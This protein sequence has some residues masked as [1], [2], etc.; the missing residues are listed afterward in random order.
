MFDSPLEL[1]NRICH[2]GHAAS[3]D[4]FLRQLAVNMSRE[5]RV[6]YVLIGCPLPDQ[7]L[8]IRTRVAVAKGKPIANFDYVLAG[9]P[10]A[11]VLS[12]E[13]VCIFGESVA[14]DFPDDKLLAEM[15]VEGYMGAPIVRPDGQLAGLAVLLDTSPFTRPG[16]LVPVMEFL[17]ARVGL[18]LYQ[19]EA[20]RRRID[21]MQYQAQRQKYA[22]L[23]QLAGGVAHDIN[24]ALSAILGHAELI[25]ADVPPD[26]EI[27][28]RTRT[29]VNSTLHAQRITQ[30]LLD[31]ARPAQGAPDA[32]GTVNREASRL[33]DLV[34]SL[35][36]QRLVL[37]ITTP[38]ERDRVSLSGT[39]IMQ[40][41]L[42]LVLNARDALPGGGSIW[43]QT[44]NRSLRQGESPAGLPEGDYLELRVRDSGAGIAAAHLPH[45]FEPFFT[46]KPVGQGTG[47][48]LAT[49]YGL[50]TAAGG[51]VDARNHPD[52]GAEF[53]ILL[54]LVDGVDEPD[55]PADVAPDVGATTRP[56]TRPGA[57]A[58]ALVLVIEDDTRIA[59][60]LDLVLGGMGYPNLIAKRGA[61]A[62]ACFR[63]RGAAIGCIISDLN[64]PDLS[65]KLVLDQ[66][67]RER[68][69]IP[70]IVTTGDPT[71]PE[72]V[73]LEAFPN[74]VLLPKPYPLK[75][76]RDHLS[77]IM[78]PR[79]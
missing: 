65:G 64:L 58:A 67:F 70:V 66:I 61:D 26:S 7:P 36:H 25:A 68:P 51:H 28:K 32:T 34:M 79:G 44:A 46:T 14:T 17:A 41:L 3:G 55:P 30:Q 35:P 27:V 38:A 31:F 72:S 9:T 54:P 73:A 16:D 49:V 76:L 69:G 1:V 78:A 77:R 75:D 43:V 21:E 57:D 39:K 19:I 2:V 20:E 59:E 5:L 18:E 6:A 13:R 62:L 37:Q 63:E 50:V 22:A 42:N 29:I 10:C 11:T 33:R 74:V 53:V 47:L 24:N 48:G 60:F 40:I 56:A 8:T 12:G 71:S 15:G 45:L 23:G 52:G 4:A